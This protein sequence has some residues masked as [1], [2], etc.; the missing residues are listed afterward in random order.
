[1]F[2]FRVWLF[3]ACEVLQTST[4]RSCFFFWY[5]TAAVIDG[6]VIVRNCQGCLAPH[7]TVWVWVGGCVWA[8][9]GFVWPICSSAAR[10]LE[11]WLGWKER[12]A[13]V[14]TASLW[15]AF[16][17]PGQFMKCAED[18]SRVQ[19]ISMLLHKPLRCL[20]LRRHP[21]TCLRSTK[22]SCWISRTAAHFRPAWCV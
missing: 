13:V 12:A 19:F 21:G 15:M 2:V 10:H 4:I 18:G 22:L 9:G 11:I 17:N 14:T 6:W 16:A 5:R 3:P 8:P 7:N 1:M 20:V